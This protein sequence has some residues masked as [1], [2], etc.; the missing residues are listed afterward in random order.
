MFVRGQ[1]TCS[2]NKNWI[3][4]KWIELNWT[5]LKASLLLKNNF[6]YFSNCVCLSVCPHVSSPQSNKLSVLFAK[7]WAGNEI[8]NQPCPI[9]RHIKISTDDLESAQ[10][11]VNE[12]GE[13]D[14]K[15]NTDGYITRKIEWK[16]C[17]RSTD[18]LFSLRVRIGKV[19]YEY[20]LR[21]VREGWSNPSRIRIALQC[22]SRWECLLV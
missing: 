12:L 5:E 17:H 8:K 10:F 15:R 14:Q 3:E 1:C 13:N 21:N 11:F 4:L 9:F 20:L 7:E 2:D 22:T 18:C 6:I 16:S 19:F